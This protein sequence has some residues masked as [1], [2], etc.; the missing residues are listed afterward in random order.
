MTPPPTAIGLWICERVIIEA[1][2]GNP[3]LICAFTGRQ[4]QRF[5]TD[6]IPFSVFFSLTDTT[7]SGI[8]RLEVNWLD[9]GENV[10]TTQR[11]IAV[12]DPLYIVN[13]HFRLQNLR[14][15]GKGVY[16]FDLF[17]DED[18]IA[19]RKLRVYRSGE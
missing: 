9:T 1:G 12:P 18:L 17:V 3:S 4:F 11:P 2:T 15:P 19:Q 8:M 16:A 14:F 5:P 6:P 7:G 10:Y 13:V